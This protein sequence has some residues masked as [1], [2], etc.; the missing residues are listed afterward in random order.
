MVYYSVL[1]MVCYF[2]VLFINFNHNKSTKTLHKYDS[3]SG[4]QVV[5]FYTKLT[6]VT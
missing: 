2:L 1:F 4:I 5:V 6:I 3:F